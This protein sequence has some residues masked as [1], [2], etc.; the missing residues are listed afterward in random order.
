MKLFKKTAIFILIFIVT[1]T[2]SPEV[3]HLAAENINL[4][5]VSNTI[6]RIELPSF[7]GNEKS[8]NANKNTTVSN[9]EREKLKEKANLKEKLIKQHNDLIQEKK[10]PDIKIEAPENLQVI[11]VSKNANL[12]KWSYVKDA[13]YQ[14]EIDGKQVDVNKQMGYI[15]KFDKKQTTHTYRIRSKCGDKYSQWSEE[16]KKEANEGSLAENS[17]ALLQSD[18]TKPLIVS[19][20]AHFVKNSDDQAWSESNSDLGYMLGNNGQAIDEIKVKLENAPSGLRVKYRIYT[21]ET[22][23]SGKRGWQDWVYDGEVAGKS[24][25]KIQGIQIALDGETT[26]YSIDYQLICSDFSNVAELSHDGQTSG[27]KDTDEVAS[28]GLPP[29]S[30]K[31]KECQVFMVN[32]KD[33]KE[34]HTEFISQDTTWSARTEPYIIEGKLI[35]NAGATLTIDKGAKVLFQKNKYR[36]NGIQINGRFIINGSDMAAVEFGYKDDG[37]TLPPNEYNYT[38]IKIESG[39][40]MNVNYCNMDSSYSVQSYITNYGQ[41]VLSNSNINMYQTPKF[42]FDTGNLKMSGCKIKYIDEGPLHMPSSAVVLGNGSGT[43]V[44]IDSCT[45]SDTKSAISLED[46]YGAV[47]ITNSE[48]VNNEEAIE[49]SYPI[50]NGDK[51]SAK[52]NIIGNTISGGDCGIDLDNR[53]SQMQSYTV[54]SNKISN[55]AKFGIFIG[56]YSGTIVCHNNTITGTD[57]QRKQNY[58]GPIVVKADCLGNKFQSIMEGV[59]PKSKD[60]ANNLLNN[61]FDAIEIDGWVMEDSK[62]PRG[63]YSYLVNG[64]LIVNEGKTLSIEDGTVVH[65]RGTLFIDGAV[66]AEGKEKSKI[67]FTSVK[68]SEY[69][70]GCIDSTNLEEQEKD[71]FIEEIYISK[72]GMFRGINIVVKNGGADIGSYKDGTRYFGVANI[73]NYGKATLINSIVSNS[74]KNGIVSWKDEGNTNSSS[75]LTVINCI[76]KDNNTTPTEE[77]YYI[78]DGIDTDEIKATI[79]NSDILNNGNGIDFIGNNAIISGNTFISNRYQALSHFDLDKKGY[80]LD[81]RENYWGSPDGPYVFDM[82][83]ILKGGNKQEIFT[84]DAYVVFY[85]YWTEPKD[86]VQIGDLDNYVKSIELRDEKL[87]G[88]PGVNTATGNYCKT[89]DDMK[90]CFKVFDVDLQHT[91]NSMDNTG[92]YLG[93]GWRLSFQGEI[94]DYKGSSEQSMKKVVLPSGE[95]QTFNINT[96]GTFTANDSRNKLTKSN[97]DYVL[98]NKEQMKYVFNSQGKLSSIA[99]KNGNT[100]TI[101][102]KTDNGKI[103]TISD[104]TGK[105]LT[106]TYDQATGYVDKIL[107]NFGSTQGRTVDFDYDSSNKL[108]KVTD[109]LGNVTNYTYDSN[110]LLQNIKNSEGKLLENINYFL[111][112]SK[113]KVKERTDSYGYTFTYEYDN[114]VNRALVTDSNKQTTEYWYDN[115]GQ[116]TM[117][118]YPDRSTRIVEYE[119]SFGEEKSVTDIYGNKTSYQRNSNGNIEVITN[120]DNTQKCM[121]YDEKNNIVKQIDECKKVTYFVYDDDKINLI[122]KVQPLNGTDSLDICT[123]DPSKASI[124]SFEYYSEEERIGNDYKVKGLLKSEKDPMGEKCIYKYDANG[125]K[126]IVTDKLSKDTIY[127]YDVYNHIKSI[128]TPMGYKTDYVYSING[129]LEKTTMQGGEI[130]RTTYDKMG[131]KK[132]EITPNLYSA[133]YD[134]LDNHSYSKNQG[135]RYTYYPDGKLETITDAMDKT[136]TYDYDCYGNIKTETKANG[137]VYTYQYDCHNRPTKTTFKEN[138]NSTSEI[139]IEEFS[140]SLNRNG[141]SKDGNKL[142]KVHKLYIDNDNYLATVSTFDYADRLINVKNADGTEKSVTYYE[143]GLKKSEKDENQNV[144]Y[145]VYDGMNRLIR[146]WVP[147]DNSTST[148]LY[149]FSGYE[150]YKDGKIHYEW[151]GKTQVN[152]DVL[153]DRS[154]TDVIEAEYEY[155]KDGKLKK[156]SDNEKR[157]TEYQYDDDRTLTKEVVYTNSD[158]S[159]Q[160]TQYQNNYLEKP[161]YKLSEIMKKDIYGNSMS[162]NSISNIWTGY[163]YDKNGNIVTERNYGVLD[164]SAIT[165]EEPALNTTKFEYDNANRLIA[166]IK[167]AKNANGDDTTITTRQN[168]TWDGKVYQSIDGNAGVTTNNYDSRGRL[169]TVVDAKGQGTYYTYDYAGRVI[170]KSTPKDVEDYNQVINAAKACYNSTPGKANWNEIYDINK[171]NIIDIYDITLLSKQGPNKTSYEY[172]AMGRV[173]REIKTI[174]DSASLKW[175]DSV[176][177]AYK[178]DNKG[179]MIKELDALGYA[180]G[181]GNVDETISSGYGI[182]YKFNAMNKKTTVLYPVSKEQ[183]KAYTYKY[184]YDTLGRKIVETNINGAT[185]KYKYNNSGLLL[186]KDLIKFDG[187]TSVTLEV[188]QYDLADNVQTKK[189]GNGNETHYEYNKLGKVSKVTT[190][191][192]STVPSSITQF[193]YDINGN[194]VY[195]E[196]SFGKVQFTNYDNA[197]RKIYEREENKDGTQGVEKFYYSD[198]N[199]NVTSYTDGNGNETSIAYDKLNKEKTKSINVNYVNNTSKQIVTSYDYDGDGNIVSETDW[200][201]NTNKYTYDVFG[202]LI[203]KRDAYDKIIER[204]TYYP[205]GTQKGSYD[206]KNNGIEFEYDSNN[207]LVK[208]TKGTTNATSKSVPQ[209]TEQ[210]YDDLG[211]VILKTVDKTKITSI[212]YDE[213]NRI[214]TVTNPLKEVTSYTYDTNGN[215]LSMTDG[216]G[217]TTKYHYNCIDKLDKTT[218]P[219][220]T[221]SVVDTIFNKTIDLST[222]ELCESYT[223][224]EDGNIKSKT[225]KSGNVTTYT[226]DV[227]GRKLTEAVG[228]ISYSYTYDGNGNPLAII[229]NTG[230][231][232]RTYD[233]LNRVVTKEVPGA[234]KTTY[235]YD[236][237]EGLESG[238]YEEVST[239][240]K[241]YAITKVFDKVSRLQQVIENGKATI[242]NYDDNGN[243]HEV[244]YPNGAKEVYEYNNVNS[245]ETLTNYNPDG[246]IIGK[247]YT[248]LYDGCGNMTQKSDD[249][250]LTTYTYDALD[251]LLTVSGPV[252]GC[253]INYTYDKSGNRSSY[254]VV[255][256]T[257]SGATG[258]STNTVRYYYDA[259]N[260]LK[261]SS[262][263]DDSTGAVRKTENIY[264]YDNNGNQLTANEKKFDPSNVLQTS[265]TTENEYDKL[266]QLVSTKT[267]EGIIVKNVYNAEGYRVQ[268]SVNDNITNYMYEGD[269]AVL[270]FD[271]TGNVTG[272]N[273]YG[274]NLISRTADG[275]TSYYMYNGHSDVTNL[276]NEAGT[277]VGTYYYDEFGNPVQNNSNVDNPFLYSGYQ[278]DKETGVYYL[279]ARMYDPV[280][281]RFLQ[282][283]TYKGDIK[284]PLSLNL[285]TYCRN[286]PV[287]YN[288]PTGHWF[289]IAIGAIV[290]AIVG[291]AANA[292]GDYLDDGKI[293]SGWKS[294]VG[295]ALEGAVIGGTTVATGGMSLWAEAGVIGVTSFVENAAN[296]YISKGE[297]NWKEAAFAGAIGGATTIGGNYVSK[298][299]SKTKTA[300]AIVSKSEQLLEAAKQRS[301]QLTESVMSR[302]SGRLDTLKTSFESF[303][304]NISSN[305][306]VTEG[307]IPGYF[308]NTGDFTGT[309]NDPQIKVKLA[310]MN[311]SSNSLTKAEVNGISE[312]AAEATKKVSTNYKETFFEKHP[313][314]RGEVVVHHSVE[315]QVLRKYPGLFTEEEIHAYESLRGIPNDVNSEVHLSKIRIE[316]NKFYKD[317]AK[318]KIEGTKENFLNKAKEIDEKF[319]DEFNPKMK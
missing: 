98:T 72:T 313:D 305:K 176:I 189:D 113:A 309:I 292:I 32:I 127:T 194:Q 266:N 10:K 20:G 24:G 12:L 26:G 78:Y 243:T 296:Q 206:A 264:T 31:D 295:S 235:M 272:R 258:A 260:R 165:G 1:F 60:T 74:Q 22:G 5:I 55:T 35:I 181:I 54:N 220:S 224:Y 250:G 169:T 17:T 52:I 298:F 163:E 210:K 231:T 280:T 281:A 122:S 70:M 276:I 251:R 129:D 125:N 172:D 77:G 173:K 284:D 143:N 73:T 13:D 222:P 29:E 262:Q 59:N 174:R 51:I 151:T 253:T 319:G 311:N 101:T 314:L 289:H 86:S 93:N 94:S 140:Y 223:Y 175:Q 7:T 48:F 64:N 291:T 75:E 318:G 241:G 4:N 106:F 283:D 275:Q 61:N 312:V 180:K 15:H 153:V 92:S 82:G 277:V 102:Y 23:Y 6:N 182:E 252:N 90:D 282:E 171:D 293:N 150:Y 118:I 19:Y 105:V 278:Y 71:K 128:T 216:R 147:E 62:L 208:T 53:P 242:Y 76:V 214:K 178:Y 146:K 133:A 195:S 80:Y 302:V 154:N 162:D 38:G 316:W 265:K 58:S 135:T 85:P 232:T 96:D 100:I 245:L 43:T 114:F 28:D 244:I 88:Q 290:G 16:Y 315:Q 42:I 36:E 155:Y 95:V 117:T 269:K 233:E 56:N 228:N 249:K 299:V 179:N 159:A 27:Y 207:R 273:T 160:V 40:Y 234:D 97:N 199:G 45:F 115:N 166:T 240:G 142:D 308:K 183:G 246:T 3:F 218:W 119:N 65:T 301:K 21:Y 25:C 294:Y 239:D 287:I 263:S 116:E 164:S 236:S 227:H 209:I 44:N 203:E 145:Y 47:N 197:G 149:A 91:Y 112:A 201:G 63:Y 46:I 255:N 69:P 226:Y 196:C 9:E 141:S 186:E 121:Y 202:K 211:N 126:T 14:L 81:L 68:D 167:Q 215:E 124:T 144:T 303:A 170:A 137:A 66:I 193:Q 205:N 136:T 221:K 188:N 177:K 238:L 274:T 57:A 310:Q 219:A 107:E 198:A 285:Y 156:K 204:L 230:T 187:T 87:F 152:K 225:D 8:G 256:Q 248:Y 192:D 2:Q 261:Y 168:Y 229:D 297:V 317:I 237:T 11:N 120:P 217:I 268:K 30:L 130:S 271:S 300:Q 104:E 213:L 161:A 89:F 279:N 257:G 247:P 39:G 67:V 200:L 212:E 191:S 103:N 286:N 50:T 307:G 33:A 259:S 83:G 34:Y 190:P 185:F 148:I 110:G 99:D 37:G 18:N 288:D 111:D 139:V 254:T 41:C 79:V 108:S 304:D 138:S 157:I 158:G 109:S 123:K 131:L 134:D 84:I 132:K 49:A 270:E 306:L 184:E 267:K